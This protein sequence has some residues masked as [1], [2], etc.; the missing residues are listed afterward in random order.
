MDIRGKGFHNKGSE[1]LAQV[2]QRGGGCP[3]RHSRSGLD[4]ALST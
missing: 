3:W 4:G 1:A 2:G